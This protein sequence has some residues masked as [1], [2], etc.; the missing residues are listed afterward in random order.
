MNESERR[1]ALADF[2]R[3]RRACLSPSEVGLPASSRR[4]TPGLRREEVAQ[5]ANIGTSW[6]VWLEQGR[7]VNPSAQVLE[8]VAQ[9]LRLTPNERR[10]LFL[11]A[12]RPLP[13]TF[14][15]SEHISPAL[16]QVLAE[17]ETT[18]AYV[19]G[20]W[21]DYLAWNRTADAL[22]TISRPSFPYARNLV[23][24]LFTSPRRRE[25]F[26]DWEQMARGVLA[27]FRAA[28]ARYPG[29][30]RFDELI[31]NLKQA[32]PEFRQWWPSHDVRSV[33]DGYKAIEHP[34][35]GL[36]SF[37]HTTL[38]VPSDPDI[39]VTIYA[40]DVATRAKLQQWLEAVVSGE[41]SA[42]SS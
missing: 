2:L 11:L 23:W 20:R 9:A 42:S 36:L 17:M 32:S 8:S 21:W 28:S 16:Q 34:R 1:Q 27:E 26:P 15:A 18:P 31:E 29:D 4:R 24:R 12:G 3:K 40:P 7:D 30:E 33:L 6:Y 25:Y 14:Q 22:F 41:S 19:T 10:H 13:P 37:E 38:L 39:R 35:L 5:L